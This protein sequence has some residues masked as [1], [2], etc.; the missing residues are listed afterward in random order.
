MKYQTIFSILVASFCCVKSIP[1]SD[2][3]A[4]IFGFLKPHFQIIEYVKAPDKKG[5]FTPT[6]VTTTQDPTAAR[7]ERCNSFGGKIVNVTLCYQASTS[8]LTFVQANNFCEQRGGR[9]WVPNV[10]D[11]RLSF[12]LFN[13]FP[14]IYK[15]I[16]SITLWI[17][18]YRQSESFVSDTGEN[19][20]DHPLIRPFLDYE[21]LDAEDECIVLYLSGNGFDLYP[22]SCSTSAR[23]FA[24]EYT[25]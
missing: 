3:K 24:C 21:Y 20:D 15:E 25:V 7:L 14:E 19:F 5:H 4:R 18:I 12:I 8:E 6:R 13:E 1:P 11:P 9:L 22:V 16:Y 23:H 10:W 17:G 2:L